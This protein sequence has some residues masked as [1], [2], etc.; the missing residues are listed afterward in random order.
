ML[1][2]EEKAVVP[3]RVSYSAGRKAS[4]DWQS[5]DIHFSYSSEVRPGETH[6]DATRRVIEYVESVLEYQ[7]RKLV[8]GI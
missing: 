7:E 5:K 6:Q 3:D 1:S 2:E 4:K 8:N